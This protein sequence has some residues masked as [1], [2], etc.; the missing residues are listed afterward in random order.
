MKVL[1]IVCVAWL[2]SA[3]SPCNGTHPYNLAGNCYVGTP[4]TNQSVRGLLPTF[5]TPIPRHTPASQLAP[6]GT[7]GSRATVA[8]WLP[9]PT[10]PTPPTTTIPIG[11]A[12]VTVL[13]ARLP[14][15]TNLALP[16]C[17]SLLSLPDWYLR[18]HESTNLRRN[19]RRWDL[20]RQR[21]NS[22]L[23]DS[24]SS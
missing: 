22:S 11:S 13:M 24:L 10:P 5:T 18:R 19:L 3:S 6:R 15:A 7:S 1:L 9:V 14:L 20:L 21:D 16:V 17:H 4:H 2:A 8:V 23:H 12:S